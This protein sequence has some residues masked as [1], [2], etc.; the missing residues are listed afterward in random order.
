M[1]CANP[2]RWRQSIARERPLLERVAPDTDDGAQ[3]TCA[4]R[5]PSGRQPL[6]VEHTLEQD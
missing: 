2:S 3:T 6:L 4:D 5:A 1:V